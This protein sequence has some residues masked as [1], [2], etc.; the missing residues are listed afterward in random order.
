MLTTNGRIMEIRLETSF[1]NRILSILN[2]YSPHTGYRNEQIN[3]Y[4]ATI[5][6]YIDTI[7][8]TYI[9][10]WCA[11]NDGQITKPTDTNNIGQ[12]ALTN[13]TDKGNEEELIQSCTKRNNICANTKKQKTTPK[14]ITQHGIAQRKQ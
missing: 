10:K 2:I 5:S 6:Q 7:P 11:D 3:T 13:K 12:C 4:W 14:Q 9:R 1:K 8:N